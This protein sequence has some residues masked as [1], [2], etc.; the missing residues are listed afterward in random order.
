MLGQASTCPR[1]PGRREGHF[2]TR[3]GA[4]LLAP[5]PTLAAVLG[6]VA[7]HTNARRFGMA[8]ASCCMAAQLPPAPVSGRA[9]R[10]RRGT[11]RKRWGQR[12]VTKLDTEL[13]ACPQG[14]SLETHRKNLEP[15]GGVCSQAPHPLWVYIQHCAQ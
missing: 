7:A 5:F 9:G 1:T 4:G 2:P 12:A 11:A 15:F 14:E 6:R 13:D 8:W 10:S 3:I